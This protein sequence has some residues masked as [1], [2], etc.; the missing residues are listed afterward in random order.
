MERPKIIVALT[1]VNEW[2]AQ[3]KSSAESAAKVTHD[4]L[5]NEFPFVQVIFHF[6][7]FM[8]VDFFLIEEKLN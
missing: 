6:W 5:I 1:F 4:K 2:E 3:N 8:N 7:V